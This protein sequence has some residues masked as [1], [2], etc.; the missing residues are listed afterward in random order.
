MASS[1]RLTQATPRY[2][3][4][5]RTHFWNDFTTRQFQRLRDR[6]GTGDVYVLV[7][8]TRGHVPGIPTERVFRLT[9]SEILAAG[10]VDSR[11]GSV[12]WF[13]GDVPLYLFQHKFPEYQYYV[14]LEYDV[15]VN[16][17][18][19]EVVG[20]VAADQADVVALSEEGDPSIWYWRSSCLGFYAPDEVSHLLVCLSIFSSGAL[21]VLASKR[22]EHAAA[23]RA[24]VTTA[25]PMCEG[26]IGSESTKQGLKVVELST[27]GDVKAYRWW[28]P[29]AERE[30]PMLDHNG[31]IHPVLEPSRFVPSVLKSEPSLRSLIS[32]LSLIHKR[33]RQLGAVGYIGAIFG[34][35]YREAVMQ[36]VRKHLKKLVAT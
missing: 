23:F 16:L 8:E 4:I 33:L 29:Y 28:P 13:S 30:L 27:Y 10:Y 17:N 14:Q 26:Y 21:R 3:V 1:S 6:V 24:G 2:A 34:K 35:P 9:D 19:D 36:P 7:D 31:F 32:P 15:N 5:F 25:W 12:Q 11:Q 20:R 22:L 18:L